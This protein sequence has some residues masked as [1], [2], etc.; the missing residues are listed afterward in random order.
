MP[1]KSY[2]PKPESTTSYAR[3]TNHLNHYNDQWECRFCKR[4]N[5]YLNSLWDKWHRFKREWDT[6]EY[7]WQTCLKQLKKSTKAACNDWR[8]KIQQRSSGFS[9]TNY[10]RRS[11]KSKPRVVAEDFSYQ[12]LNWKMYGKVNLPWIPLKNNRCVKNHICS[13]DKIKCNVWGTKSSTYNGLKGHS[14]YSDV[15]PRRSTITTLGATRF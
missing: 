13:I 14:W 11:T 12:C 4:T 1:A 8:N 9:Q 15:A 2:Y 3:R 7:H 6:N 5:N 10:M